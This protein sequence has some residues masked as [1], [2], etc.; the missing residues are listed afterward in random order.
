[1]LCVTFLKR[2]NGFGPDVL[3]RRSGLIWRGGGGGVGREGGYSH[4]YAI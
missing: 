4:T 2:E 1:M 3:S